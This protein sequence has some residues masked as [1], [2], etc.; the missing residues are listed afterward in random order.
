L[1]ICE[2]E[3]ARDALRFSCYGGADLFIQNVVR[4]FL[5]GDATEAMRDNSVTSML[6]PA[7]L[8]ESTLRRKCHVSASRRDSFHTTFCKSVNA[9]KK[10]MI[11]ASAWNDII[12]DITARS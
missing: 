12:F 10:V 6:F 3:I 1:T 2:E 4:K 11:F 7:Y 8:S 5:S 9:N